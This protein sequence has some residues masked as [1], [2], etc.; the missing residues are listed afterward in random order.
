MS[1]CHASTVDDDYKADTERQ[2]CALNVMLGIIVTMT[3]YQ[4]PCHTLLYDIPCYVIYHIYSQ[5]IIL[6]TN[7]FVRVLIDEAVANLTCSLNNY[8]Y[9]D[10]TYLIIASD[11]GGKIDLKRISKIDLKIQYSHHTLYY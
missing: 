5:I 2:Y 8:G 1:R 10:N 4:G 9:N 7:Y 11:N 6:M 3:P